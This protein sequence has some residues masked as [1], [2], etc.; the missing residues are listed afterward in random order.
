ME[1]TLKQKIE[2]KIKLDIFKLVNTHVSDYEKDSYETDNQYWVVECIISEHFKYNFNLEEI[3][4]SNDKI[5]S[6]LI[7]EI[8]EI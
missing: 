2:N 8:L 6:N 7:Q 3:F 1:Y 4:M 5:S